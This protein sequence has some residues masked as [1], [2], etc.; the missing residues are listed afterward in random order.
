MGKTEL[1]RVPVHPGL[2][3]IIR[4]VASEHGLSLAEFVREAAAA[5]AREYLGVDEVTFRRM[6]ARKGVG[7]ASRGR[8]SRSAE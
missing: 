5:Q 7:G 8:K 1:L 3:E 6:V 2:K 4:S